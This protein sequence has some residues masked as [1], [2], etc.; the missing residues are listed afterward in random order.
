MLQEDCCPYKGREHLVTPFG[1]QVAWQAEGN[2]V[3]QGSGEN[4]YMPNIAEY[5]ASMTEAYFTRAEDQPSGPCAGSNAA[6]CPKEIGV[7]DDHDDKSDEC[8]KSCDELAEERGFQSCSDVLD[9]LPNNEHLC[10]G[11][12]I[13][14]DS[15]SG[16]PNEACYYECSKG[17]DLSQCSSGVF[18]RAL[19]SGEMEKQYPKTYIFMH[20]TYT[21]DATTVTGWMRE[22][23]ARRWRVAASGTDHS[24]PWVSFP[25]KSC[26]YSWFLEEGDDGCPPPKAVA[27]E[28]VASFQI[29]SYGEMCLSAGDDGALLFSPC[30]SPAVSDKQRWVFTHTP[31]GGKAYRITPLSNPG[32][33]V[34]MLCPNA[35]LSTAGCIARLEECTDPVL[36][37]HWAHLKTPEGFRPGVH[38]GDDKFSFYLE[39]EGKRYSPQDVTDVGGLEGFIRS[40]LGGSELELL[41]NDMNENAGELKDI[42]E[43]D[44]VKAASRAVVKRLRWYQR[45]FSAATQFTW[46]EKVVR[47]TAC[48]RLD[49][50]AGRSP[51]RLGDWFRRRLGSETG[52]AASFSRCPAEAL[53]GG[54]RGPMVKAENVQHLFVI[55]D[56]SQSRGPAVIA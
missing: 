18:S 25:T 56:T 55:R 53:P 46:G 4:A 5:F 11:C 29:E 50:E 17:P 36:P 41:Q 40:G 28:P 30:A 16:E 13:C 3:K 39:S 42:K 35:H 44:G 19:N 23:Y 10:D 47:S 6:A 20:D 33:C 7:C 43:K 24:C 54:L 52:S 26:A 37:E 2:L 12:D 15:G 8:M 27:A 38:K 9:L 51:R 1:L 32:Q 14:H 22:E 21:A 49:P 45:I 34:S 31:V 48:L